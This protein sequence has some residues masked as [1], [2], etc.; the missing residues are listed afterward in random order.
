MAPTPITI[1]GPAL[2]KRYSLPNAPQLPGGFPGIY[3]P[4]LDTL[5][6][7]FGGL[8]GIFNPQRAGARAGAQDA[9]AG[10]G[11]FSFKQDDPNTPEDE[12]LV[13]QQDTNAAL[14]QRQID[15]VNQ[16][17][18]AQNA[19]GMLDSSQTSD[20][21]GEALGNIGRFALGIARQY[22]GQLDQIAAN[23]DQAAQGIIGDYQNVVSQGTA[24]ALDHPPA[25]SVPPT[26]PIAVPAYNPGAALGNQQN[27]SPFKNIDARI[28][29]GIGNAGVVQAGRNPS[30][31]PPRPRV[32]R[33]AIW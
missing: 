2:S 4:Q 9:L 13:L 31:A 22:Q 16:T 3:Q 21:V 11:G 18:W 24:W 30:A 26:A 32:A 33:R 27:A 29:A 25:V 17:R 12:S 15:A 7:R 14:G 19:R 28:S 23:E 1:I 10:I 8:G 20:R 6:Q 5:S